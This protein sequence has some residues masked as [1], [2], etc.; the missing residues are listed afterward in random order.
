MQ[1]KQCL[2][3][4]NIQTKVPSQK[5]I[6]ANRKEKFQAVLVTAK[7]RDYSPH[8]STITSLDLFQLEGVFAAVIFYA[9]K[10]GMKKSK[11]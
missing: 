2:N 9:E 8:K 4:K 10:R 1:F 11:K 7:R 5:T 6:S 3:S